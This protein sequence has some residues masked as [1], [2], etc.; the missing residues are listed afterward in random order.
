MPLSSV[1]GKRR[2]S[3]PPT[4]CVEP[5]FHSQGL[6]GA[7]F[8]I[9]QLVTENDL[10][11]KPVSP[12][13]QHS[14]ALL[15]ASITAAGAAGRA[16][17]CAHATGRCPGHH[18]EEDTYLSS[19]PH[20]HREVVMRRIRGCCSASPGSRCSPRAAPAAGTLAQPTSLPA[21]TDPTRTFWDRCSYLAKYNQQLRDGTGVL[22]LPLPDSLIRN[23]RDLQ[24]SLQ[25]RRDMLLYQQLHLN[26]LH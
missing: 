13:S 19:A 25:V 8:N 3:V 22:L 26:S 4:S 1:G 6:A 9:T 24:V 12:S 20:E 23:Q 11:S 7:G 10:W 5:V 15:C 2:G 16:E 21:L 17:L 18:V 14:P